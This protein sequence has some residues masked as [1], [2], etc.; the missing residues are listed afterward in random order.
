MRKST[1]GGALALVALA[2][3]AIAGSAAGRT[4]AAPVITGFTPTHA[5]PGQQVTIM[6]QNFAGT[7]SVQFGGVTVQQN[8]GAASGF[9]VS[10]D[11]NS[12]TATI[13][14]DSQQG[15][16]NVVV[17]TNEGQATSAVTFTVDPPGAGTGSPASPAK[18]VNRTPKI[19]IFAPLR[20]RAGARITITGV[21]LDGAT[22]VK[23]GGVASPKITSSMRKITAIV[24]KKA[25]SG[26]V[27]IGTRHGLG[28]SSRTF[29][30]LRGSI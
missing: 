2:A 29:T 22:W 23:F 16:V 7:T 27:T 14:P 4:L 20:A 8:P 28:T 1:F 6:G 3:C 5:M 12:I 9:T 30:F 21:N 26:K 10:S 25:H 13:P 19:N 18:S 15:K 17:T 24:P 11:G